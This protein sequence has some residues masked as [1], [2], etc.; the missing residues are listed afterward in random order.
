MCIKDYHQATICSGVNPLANNS[1]TSV[2]LIRMLRIH[3]FPP[4]WFGLNVIRSKSCVFIYQ[5][6]K[7]L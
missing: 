6:Y 4:H 1:M 2:T 3:G 7:D 5:K